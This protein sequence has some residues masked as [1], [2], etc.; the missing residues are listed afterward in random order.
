MG[1]FYGFT[2]YGLILGQ[3]AEDTPEVEGLAKD[4]E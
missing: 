4:Y 1:H 3:M 2:P